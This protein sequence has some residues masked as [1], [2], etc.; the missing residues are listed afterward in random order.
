MHS[1]TATALQRLKG[2]PSV[3]LEAVFVDG[4]SN[5]PD[6]QYKKGTRTVFSISVDVYGSEKVAQEV[7]KRLSKAHTYLQH[8]VCLKSDVPYNN[9][10]YYAIPGVQEADVALISP[11]SEREDQL[12]PAVDIAK[13]FEEVEHARRLPT[14]NA[15]WHVRTPLLEYA[16][17]F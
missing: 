5:R 10:H 3:R 11:S 9:P 6:Q 2:S 7:G 4:E 12:D 1:R 8:P 15:D 17:F 13:V 16:S 14:M